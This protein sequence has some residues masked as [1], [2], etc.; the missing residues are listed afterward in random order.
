MFQI[1]R[2]TYKILVCE[3]CTKTKNA[4]SSKSV[5]IV[6]SFFEEVYYNQICQVELIKNQKQK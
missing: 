3:K 4:V 6:Q 1:S 2:K 5:N